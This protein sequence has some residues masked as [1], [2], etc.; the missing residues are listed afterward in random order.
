MNLSRPLAVAV[1]VI[2]GGAFGVA[3]G[4]TQSVSLNAIGDQSSAYYEYYSDGFAR[5]DQRD[6]APNEFRQRLHQISNPSVSYGALDV[7]PNDEQF[8]FGSVSY[9]DAGLVN[10]Y[11][12]VPV[13]AVNLGITKDPADP[14][15]LNWQ[16]FTTTT[17]LHD[18]S[19]WVTVY[20]NQAVSVEL[21]ASIDI[22]T[23][24][25]LGSTIPGVYPGTFSIDGNRFGVNVAGAPVLDLAF[26]TGP[27]SLEWAFDGKISALLTLGDADGND[28]V[29]AGDYT[30]WA[31][32]FLNTT[33]LG[34]AAGDYNLD[35]I[36]DAG[37][38]TIWADHFSPSALSASAVPEPSSLTMVG[39]GAATLFVAYRRRI[40]SRAA[41][42]A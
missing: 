24:G 23:T 14:A 30:T 13:T 38:Y 7:F 40:K 42:T 16:R 39:I 26:G 5:I 41:R 12:K 37:D 27:F 19:G 18:F 11:G 9:D 34:P 31:D 17:E 25:A 35:G 2:A 10:G 20:D 8:R 22:I 28:V 36:V 32:N 1:L 33:A 6:P 15:Y 4:A 3:R 29:D 21:N